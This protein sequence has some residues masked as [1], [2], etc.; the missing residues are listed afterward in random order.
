VNGEIYWYPNLSSTYFTLNTAISKVEIYSFSGQ[1]AKS[2]NANQV[3]ENQ[4]P[5]SDVN[6][7]L[8]IAKTLNG[9][10]KVKVIK[11]VKQ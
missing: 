1:L 8:Y 7:G 5:I 9:N 3:K 6:M 2:F 11:L 10:N 4:F